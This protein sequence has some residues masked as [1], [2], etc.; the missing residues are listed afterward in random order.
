MSILFPDAPRFS[1]AQT[2]GMPAREWVLPAVVPRYGYAK[3]CVALPPGM[4]DCLE[5][6]IVH[7]A[8]GTEYTTAV[9][10]GARA[11]LIHY[12]FTPS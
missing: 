12:A 10:Y 5:V 3:A 2:D 11:Y 1:P 9:M 8:E 4:P 6:S 7:S